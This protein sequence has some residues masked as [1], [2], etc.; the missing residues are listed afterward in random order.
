VRPD[1]VEQQ[2]GRHEQVGEVGEDEAA[3]GEDQQQ[4]DRHHEEVL[5]QPGL[6]ICRSERQRQPDDR[7]AAEQRL[8][9]PVAREGTTDVDEM[10]FGPGRHARSI[11]FRPFPC[12]TSLPG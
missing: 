11:P 1:G 3:M 4:S 6:P 5:E 2:E 7:I 12:R 8:Q 9:E 10:R